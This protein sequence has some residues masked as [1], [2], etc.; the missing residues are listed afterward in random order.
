[1]PRKSTELDSVT[2]QVIEVECISGAELAPETARPA[3]YAIIPQ[4]AWSVF[5]GP[6]RL[7]I[8]LHFAYRS[9]DEDE[10]GGWYRM[11]GGLANRAGL[12]PR[13][14]RRN[15]VNHLEREGVIE[16][17]RR[18]GLSSLLRLTNPG[19]RAITR[20]TKSFRGRT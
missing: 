20:T 13:S 2:G 3:L 15:A 6:W 10:A 17:R 14:S 5:P 9:W 1:M 19:P 8:A 16:V 12:V 7:L 4:S 18:S 11:S